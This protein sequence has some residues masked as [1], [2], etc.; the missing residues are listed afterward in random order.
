[1]NRLALLLLALFMTTSSITAKP[2]QPLDAQLLLTSSSTTDDK[3]T[4]TLTFQCRPWIDSDKIKFQLDLPKEFELLE[5]FSFWEGQ[6][7]ANTLFTKEI[8]LKAPANKKGLIKVIAI[9]TN[10]NSQS[11]KVNQVNLETDKIRSKNTELPFS[12][13]SG[14]KRFKHRHGVIRRE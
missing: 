9:M 2:R 11:V 1:M 8:I 3:S 7:N 4:Y 13:G 10:E 14:S 6:L 12:Y 5:G